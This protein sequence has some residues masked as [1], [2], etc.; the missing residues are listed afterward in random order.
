MDNINF[1]DSEKEILSVYRKQVHNTQLLSKDKLKKYWTGEI[2][3]E[4]IEEK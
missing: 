4:Q 1:N 3:Y 2:G